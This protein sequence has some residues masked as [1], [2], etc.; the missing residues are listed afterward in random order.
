MPSFSNDRGMKK[1]QGFLL[2]EHATSMESAKN[3]PKWQ[4]VMDQELIYQVLHQVI[5]HRANI[6]IQLFKAEGETP[7]AYIEGRIVGAEGDWLHVQTDA[8]VKRVDL[9]AIR[10]VEERSFQ[11]WYDK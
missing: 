6:T 2:S 10:Y 1:W 8:G 11:K 3:A 4:D 7:D 9:A 5:Q